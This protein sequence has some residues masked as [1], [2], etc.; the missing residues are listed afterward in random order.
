VL[1]GARRL[2]DAGAPT[3]R[4]LAAAQQPLII[5]NARQRGASR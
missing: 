3:R 4:A 2:G 5:E 1:I